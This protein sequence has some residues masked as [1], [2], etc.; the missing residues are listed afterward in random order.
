MRKYLYNLATDQN[1]GIVASLL[2]LLLFL[3]SLIY[4][5][6]IRLISLVLGLVKI[7]LRA[8][9][10]S[11]GNIT[12]GGTGKTSLVEYVAGFLRDKGKS[13]A[14]LTRGYG[15]GDEP[16]MLEEN[17]SGVAVIVGSDRIRSGRRAIKEYCADTLIL[18]D[19]FQQ[20]HLEKGLDIV[21]IDANLPFGNRNM[22]PRGILREPLSALRRA[23]VFVLTKTD[24]AQGVDKLKDDL[25]R[26]NPKADIF[27]SVH[28]PVN[29][30]RMNEPGHAL[31]QGALKG[32]TAAIFCGIGDPE[33]F[34]RL[35]NN[36]GIR[37]AI[38]H[39][40]HDH[41]DYT[42]ADL[43]R[44]IAEAGRKS[45]DTIITTEKDASRIYKSGLNDFDSKFLVLRVELA[46]KEHEK[47]NLR[48]LS[49]YSV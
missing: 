17:L 11:I 13:V 9:V 49:L 34:E 42:D 29:F 10:I 43:E 18:D 30:Y 47:F 15:T 28:R 41:Y 19:G 1:R 20:W 12:L 31:P 3:L 45:V 39:I 22:I 24:L 33:S 6:V 5:M 32:K 14:I 26:I 36:C 21:T 35:I 48:L 2:K 8:K 44:I 40:F 7:S 46:I 27:E 25:R 16:R 37:V 23:Q 38:S 4:G